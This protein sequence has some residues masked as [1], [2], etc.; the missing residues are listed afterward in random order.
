MNI[1]NELNEKQR[2]AVTHKNGPLLVIAGPGTGKTKVITHRIAYLIR[3]HNIKP[4]NILAIT[5][6]NKAAEEMQ[7]RINSEIGEPHGSSVKACTFHAFCVKV[8]RKHATQIGL[9]ENFT[10]FDQEFQDEILTES[11]RELSLNPDDY[12]PWLLRNVI[13]DAKCKLQNPVDAADTLDIYESGTIENIR[14]VLQSYQD[15][16]DEYDALD[17]DDLLVKTVELL[18][19]VA[20]V[21]EAYRR[22]IS[23][24]L[25][26]EYHDVNNVQYRLLQLLCPP[27]E[28]NLMVVADE[29]QAIYSWRGSNPQYIEDFKIDFN[30]ETLTLDDHYRCSEK[31]LRAAEEVI[32]KNIERQKQ[33]TLRTHKDVGRDI[34]HYTFDT[35]VAEALGV[36]DVI[37]KLVEQRNYSYRDIAIF[38]RTHRLADVLAEQLLRA[39]IQFQRVQPMNSFGEGNSKSILAYLRFI[40]WQLPQDLERAINFPETCIDDLTWVRLK[41]LAQREHIAFIELLKNIEAYPQDVG[42]LTRRNVRQFWTQ[43]EDLSTEIEGEAVDK[44]ILKLFDALEQSRSAYRAEELEVIERQPELSNLTTAQDVLYSA[45]DL[46]EPIQI[47]ASHGIDEYCAAHIIH[48]TLET[49]LDHTA[50]LQFLPPDEND[51]TQMANGVHIL[52]GDFSE[53]GESGR[54]ART[55]LIGTADV[56]DTDA[57]H[58]GTE[59]VRSLAALK[60]CQRLINRFE[61]PNMADMVVYDLET[62]GINPKTAEIVEIAAQRLSAIGSE[63]ERFHSLVKPPG[64]HIPRAATRIHRID[65]ETVKDSPGIEIVLPELMGFLQDRILIGHNVAEYDNPILARDLRRY[66]SRDLSAPHYDTLATAR[67]LFPRQRCSMG[68]LAEKFGIEH[69]RLHGALE[70]VEVNREIFKELIKIDAYKREVKSLT[71][72]LPLV[73]IGILAKTGASPTKETLTETDAFLNAAKR[74]VQMHDPKLPDRFPLEAAEAE[75]ATAYMEELQDVPPPEF[76]EDLAWRQRRIQFMN[77]VLHFESMSDTNRLTDF[78]DYQK[79]LTNVDELDDT[80]EQLTLMTLHAAKGTEFP[81]VIIIGMEEGSFPMWRQ[82]ITEAELEEE[83]RLFYV[84]MTRAQAQLYLSSVTYR[85]GDRDRASSMFVREI[86]SNYV[87]RWSPQRRR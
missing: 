17:F 2:E 20:E 47:T 11:V 60:L 69:G 18:E 44:I 54:D 65:A 43:L 16:L 50:Q 72:L 84:G 29:D 73:G 36:I 39:N 37:R 38:Y 35:P 80:T 25:V 33:H 12:P 3:E 14:S 59:G 10:I 66:L 70:D 41:W 75:Q 48:Q 56:I 83:R 63:V 55:I 86:P 5:F 31:I 49:Y 45:I 15:K 71:E 6:T 24:I 57:I 82:D 21:R 30:P 68:A 28:G 62:T 1:L 42:P 26:D 23:Y 52:I 46:D 51:V 27:P 58:L 81:I 79:L 64:G 40:Q 22:E 34:F 7:E 8:L 87:I 85:F 67:R 4:E 53:I 19:R 61:S 77:A 74:V 78:L 32:S 13:S 76:P 9:S